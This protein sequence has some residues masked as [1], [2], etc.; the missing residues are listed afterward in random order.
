MALEKFHYTIGKTKI[1]LPLMG[2]LPL[3][4]ARKT[5]HADT[6]EQL[7]VTFETLFEEGSREMDALDSL[8]PDEMN[9]LMSE[10]MKASGV[11]LGEST[12]S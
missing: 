4:I 5:R 1:E 3:G 9:E 12:A 11:T 7:F 10:W 2:N 6:S 8:E